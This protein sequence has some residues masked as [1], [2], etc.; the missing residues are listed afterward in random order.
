MLIA[1]IFCQNVDCEP[2]YPVT[3]ISVDGGQSLYAPLT[4][5]SDRAIERSKE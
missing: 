4:T 2:K 3:I 1:P 5:G